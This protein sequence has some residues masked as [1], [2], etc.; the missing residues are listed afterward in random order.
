MCL[1]LSLMMLSANCR[2]IFIEKISIKIIIVKT[3]DH[4]TKQ[5]KKLIAV[6]TK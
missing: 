6:Q 1:V 5:L 3:Y 2:C 4:I